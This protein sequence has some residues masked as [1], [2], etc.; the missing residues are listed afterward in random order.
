MGSSIQFF[1]GPADD[2]ALCDAARAIGL[3]LLTPWLDQLDTADPD[4]PETGAFWYLSTVPTAGLHPYG[5]PPVQVSDATDPLIELLRGY[6]VPPFLVAGRLYCSD[7]VPALSRQT[8]PY[9]SRLARWVRSNWKRRTEDGY[10]I[11]PE[12]MRLVAED[13]AQVAYIPPGVE[14]E[15]R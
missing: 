8:K 7:D 5:S 1:A 2:R 14:I 6:Y 12:A 4:K 11:G 10:Y 3:S 9:F 13:Q 15:Q